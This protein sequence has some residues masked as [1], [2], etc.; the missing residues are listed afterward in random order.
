MLALFE[1]DARGAAIV[2][3]GLDEIGAHEFVARAVRFTDDGRIAMHRAP[4]ESP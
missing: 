1:S 2:V 4:L 3:T